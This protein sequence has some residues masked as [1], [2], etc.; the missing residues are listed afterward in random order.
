[1]E[2]NDPDRPLNHISTLWALVCQAQTGSPEASSAAQ[3]QLLQRYRGAV[4]RYL[5]AAVRDDHAADDLAQE[6]A[7]RF[8]QGKLRG[9]DP[10]QGRFRDYLKGVLAHLIADYYRQRPAPAPLPP[11]GPEPAA[12]PE[13]AGDSRAFLASWRQELLA[14]TWEALDGIERRTGQPFHTVLAFRRDHPELRSAEMAERLA[15]RLG[16]PL[17]AAGVRQTLR[18]A[19]DKFADLLLDEV[20]Q[21]LRQPTADQLGQELADLELLQYC[22]PALDRYRAG[23]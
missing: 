9:A 2:P 13:P 12:P 4:H 1:M 16:K 5:L 3:Q 8:I 19:R 17:T 6:F 15:A 11:D 10:A 21:T 14:R 18:R 23:A 22:Q 20:A 7:L